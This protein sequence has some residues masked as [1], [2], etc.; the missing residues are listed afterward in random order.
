ME[1]NPSVREALSAASDLCDQSLRF[2]AGQTAEKGEI[3]VEKV[4]QRQTATYD[5]VLTTA[6]VH[7]ARASISHADRMAKSASNSSIESLL[8]ETLAAETVANTRHR[9]GSRP[10]S[11]GVKPGT[12]SRL[13]DGSPFSEAIT[14]A[15]DPSRYSMIAGEILKGSGG[16]LGLT[17][18]QALMRDA[19]RKFA[20][21]KVRAV[22]EK[23]HREDELIPEPIIRELSDMGCFGLSIPQKFG[24]FQ[25]DEK[26]D[27]MGMVIVTEELSRG[28][29][30]VSGSL[31]T[32][33]EIL[34]KA[35]LK[36]GT[37]E[38][39][40]KWLP[41]MA[42][43]RKMVAVGV[44]EPD[45][46][47]DVAAMKCSATPTDGGWLLNGA[48]TWCTFA[49]RA[50]ILMIL[51]RTDPD[52]S[53]KHRGLSVLIV[54]KPPFSGHNF[55]HAQDK[56]GRVVGRAIGT[57]GYRGMHSYEL[58]FEDFFVPEENLIGGK[59]G[60]GKGF[61]LQMEG[62]SGGRL[63]TAAR[64]NGV[65]QAAF[66]K[67]LSY[68]QERKVFGRPICDYELTRF[69]LARM[70][71]LIQGTRQFTYAVAR[72][73][74]EGKGQM[75]ASM[76]KFLASRTSEWVAREAQQ[77]HGGMGYAEEYD[78][79]RYFVDARVFSIFEGA[80]EVLAL[81]VIAR[82]LLDQALKGK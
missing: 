67:A 65:M 48:K 82:A 21:T 26:P 79:S 17:E 76:V 58:H 44:T 14:Q 10:Q 29:L 16:D 28:S 72:M 13:L 54:E 27:N 2:L 50:E 33:P 57:I 24:G 12:I 73:F 36:G 25:N 74:D 31:I 52:M 42:S 81:R 70:A 45:F 56:G 7:A 69:K 1:V 8:A 39:K 47:S 32:R 63:Q 40:E 78:V 3:S 68:S 30:G 66:E 11:Y 51:A 64:A 80:E 35:L 59:D 5:L 71:M 20:D 23:V 43:G 60:L 46:G 77:I 15:L 34:S 75:E 19:F 9:L 53:K 49:G 37:P 4:D 22:A 55:E 18:E 41:L 61:Y 38:Q 62:F 6:E